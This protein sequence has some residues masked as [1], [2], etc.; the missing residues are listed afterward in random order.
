MFGTF[1]RRV[2][3]ETRKQVES[4][5]KAGIDDGKKIG[6]GIERQKWEMR[7]QTLVNV[8]K[9]VILEWYVADKEEEGNATIHN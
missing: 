3:E 4:A 6:R 1:R 2:K 7:L 8:Q 5:Y 9:E